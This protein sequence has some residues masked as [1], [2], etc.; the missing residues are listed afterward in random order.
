[1]KK[2]FI[3]NLKD[4][5]LVDSLFAVKFKKPPLPYKAKQGKWFEIRIADKSGEATLKYWGGENEDI[6][7]L[8]NSISEGDVI[9][10]NGKA[11]ARG[12]KIEINV[13][14]GGVER[15]ENFKIEDFIATSKKDIK[16]IMEKIEE[17]IENIQNKHLKQ[18]L[19]S[20]FGDEKFRE[21]FMKAPAAMHLHQNWIGGLAEHTYNVTEICIKVAELYPE[22]NKELLITGALLHDIGKTEELESK[23][24]INVT[25]KGM[26]IGHLVEGTMLVREHI[27]KID[28]FPKPLEN[29][30][31]HMLLSHH[32]KLENGS[33][34]TPIFP[35]ALVLYI[36]DLMDSQVSY[37]LQL[38]KDANT[39]SD[40]IWR[41][42]FGHVFLK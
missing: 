9:K 37:M 5:E 10:V 2:Q 13:N 7:Q 8:Y 28:G 15:T 30:I 26:L 18:L 27:N 21:K 32:G 11:R 41:R 19:N 34:K 6:E 17:L 40:W 38:K 4:G 22:L 23:T 20:F 33:P 39:E 31:I 35:E 16:K 25:E 3:G 24:T 12:D 42:N 29:K 36:A 14:E 1:M